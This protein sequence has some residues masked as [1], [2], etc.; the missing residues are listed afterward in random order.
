MKKSKA[1]LLFHPAFLL[2]LVV[3]YLNDI[4]WKYAFANWLTGKLSDVAGMVV[5]PVFLQALLPKLTAKNASLGCALLFIW[6]KLPVSQ[7]VIDLL[8]NRFHLSV[9]RTV[10]YPDLFALVFLPLSLKLQPVPPPASQIADNCLRW[11]LGM[12]T[13][14][15]LCATTVPYRR[16]FQTYPEMEQ[17][18]FGETIT[19]KRPVSA[20][21][22]TLSKKGIAYKKDSV[23][24]YAISNQH[25]LY[26]RTN[27]ASDTNAIWQQVSQRN[28][29]T[30]YVK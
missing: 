8:R 4:Y 11:V 30:I 1:S 29:S 18:Y 6:W 9:N 20:V 24:Y 10:D 27:Q 21:L 14:F 13:F 23:T 16:L 19:Q 17:L 22:E 5:F 12:V 2:A 25:Q 3:L 28:D 26:Y 15:F 7:P